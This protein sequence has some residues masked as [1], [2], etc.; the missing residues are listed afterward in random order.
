MTTPV[1]YVTKDACRENHKTNWKRVSIFTGILAPLTLAILIGTMVHL[2]ESTGQARDI[3]A[4]TKAIVRVETTFEKTL[5]KIDARLEK[6]ETQSETEFKELKRLI[7]HESR[8]TNERKW[9]D[10][11]R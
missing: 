1:A 5:N 4:N 10:D 2:Q 7:I 3:A 9:T 6:I 8:N 11:F